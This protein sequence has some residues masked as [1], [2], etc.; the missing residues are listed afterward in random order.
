MPAGFWMQVYH[1]WGLR[2]GIKGV[3]DG[4][5][6]HPEELRLGTRDPLEAVVEQ[7]LEKCM[8]HWDKN[9][10]ISS[11]EKTMGISEWKCGSR[12]VQ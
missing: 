12:L 7:I 11:A 6:L 10:S 4:D 5:V 1:D 9:K 8:G 2:D 3:P